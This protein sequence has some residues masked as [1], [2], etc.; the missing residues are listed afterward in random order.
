MMTRTDV[1]A[2]AI[3]L[4]TTK[5]RKS[6]DELNYKEALER[7]RRARALFLGRFVPPQYKQVFIDECPTPNEP[8]NNPNLGRPSETIPV[9]LQRYPGF[10][11]TERPMGLDYRRN[12]ECVDTL[13]IAHNGSR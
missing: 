4:Q 3:L 9:A 5:P 8:H 2:V 10:D 7:W 11:P 6:S 13:S 1:K 12:E